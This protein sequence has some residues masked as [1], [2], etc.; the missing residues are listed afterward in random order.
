[1]ASDAIRAIAGDSA[2][3]ALKWSASIIQIA[4]YAATAFGW[5]PWNLFFFLAGVTGWFVVGVLWNDR[6]LMLI[7]V[8]AFAVLIAGMQDGQ[9]VGPAGVSG[10]P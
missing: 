4:G 10:G 9:D 6:A 1:M 2:V 3:S 7:H 5:A 8:V